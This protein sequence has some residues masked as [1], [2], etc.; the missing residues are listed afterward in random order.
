MHIGRKQPQIAYDLMTNL[1]EKFRRDGQTHLLPN[2]RA[3][4][5]WIELLRGDV[6][7]AEEW[8]NAEAPN[9]DLDFYIMERYRYLVKIK[10]YL[11]TGRPERAM[12]LI[13]RLEVCFEEHHRTYDKLQN[14]LLRAIVQYRMKLGDWQRSLAAA[15]QTAQDYGFIRVV[16][17]LGAAILPLLSEADNLGLDPGYQAKVMQATGEFALFY[18]EFLKPPQTMEEPLTD[19]EQRILELLCTNA[20]LEE[21][22]ALCGVSYNTIKYHN[23]NIYRK[24]GVKNRQQAQI[25]AKKLGLY[26]GSI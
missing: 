14:G 21:I 12:H 13:E 26:G 9:E 17:E 7:K 10:T 24:L 23:R 20:A 11:A 3:F 5:V 22:A 16:S 1:G 15:L 8:M 19:T 6:A 4:L 25:E 2:L 18:P